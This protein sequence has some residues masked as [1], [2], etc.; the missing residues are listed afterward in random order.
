MRR[1]AK[2]YSH[3]EMLYIEDSLK[4]K[5]TIFQIARSLERATSG[6]YFHV[7]NNGGPYGYTAEN[8]RQR[9][10]LSRGEKRNILRDNSFSV[11]VSNKLDSMQ[12]QI[13][14]LTQLVREKCK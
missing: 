2:Q 13:N 14:L 7:N 11:V 12:L 8:A 9:Q 1:A 3:E 6:L 5:K 10:K 4:K